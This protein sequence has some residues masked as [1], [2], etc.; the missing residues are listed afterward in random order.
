MHLQKLDSFG[1]GYNKD[2]GY[3]FMKSVEIYNLCF[4]LDISK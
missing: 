2:E 4:W 3:S 1:D